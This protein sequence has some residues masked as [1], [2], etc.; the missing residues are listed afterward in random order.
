MDQ[1]NTKRP[2]E[3]TLPS[4]FQIKDKVSLLIDGKV[5]NANVSAVHF[6]PSKVKYDLTV[7][8]KSM[9]KIEGVPDGA[10]VRTR[11]YNVDGAFVYERPSSIREPLNEFIDDFKLLIEKANASLNPDDHDEFLNGIINSVQA[12]K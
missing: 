7:W 3:T 1:L 8:F 9:S 11:L 4:R 12:L 6:L 10:D 5:I 2:D